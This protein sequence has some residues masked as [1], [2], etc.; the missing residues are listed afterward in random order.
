MR[1]QP[2]KLERRLAGHEQQPGVGWFA[3]HQRELKTMPKRPRY[4]LLVLT[5]VSALAHA[6]E[7][8][9]PDPISTHEERAEQLLRQALA[10]DGGAGIAAAV[11]V[12]GQLRFAGAAGH[13]DM[14]GNRPLRADTPLRIGSV[15]KLITTALVCRLIDAQALDPDANIET[16]VPEFHVYPEAGASAITARRLANHTSGIR[17]YDFAD[18]AEANNQRYYPDLAAALGVFA[19]DP[20]L[21]SPGAEHHYSSFGYNLLGVAASRAAEASFADAVQSLVSDPLGLSQTVIDHP[22]QLVVD[23][24]R[25]YTVYHGELINTFWRDSSDYYPS[26][27]MLSSAVDLARLT[28]AMFHG[29]FLSDQTRSLLTSESHSLQ[30]P[31]GYSFGWQVKIDTDGSKHYEHGGETNGAYAWV[32]YDP[33]RRLV[34]AG[35]ANYNVF[36]SQSESAF[37]SLAMAGLTELYGTA[38]GE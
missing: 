16:L 1:K 36:P 21:A 10:D 14:E 13:A 28:E 26:G 29:D 5:L 38:A 27:G 8:I 11:L 15:S 17:H 24:A 31:T 32:Y 22:L 12:N 35:A 3:T 7:P 23:R 9:K 18:L 37:F 33:E 20:L 2:D 19:D 6:D 25:F 30:G 4:A 34:V